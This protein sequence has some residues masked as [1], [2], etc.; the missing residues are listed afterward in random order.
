MM[1]GPLLFGFIADH[2]SL[3]SAFYSAG[4]IGVLATGACYALANAP[5]SEPQTPTIVEK[6][7]VVAD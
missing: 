3:A 7:S 2:I 6:E 4:L 5:L 1:V